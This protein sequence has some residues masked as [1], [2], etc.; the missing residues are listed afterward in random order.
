MI[1][2]G[3]NEPEIHRHIFLELDTNHNNVIEGKEIEN[4]KNSN[5]EKLRAKLKE[6]E[7][8]S[9]GLYCTFFIYP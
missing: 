1:G 7:K 9:S 5:V 6:L 2:K 3:I 4:G 8:Q